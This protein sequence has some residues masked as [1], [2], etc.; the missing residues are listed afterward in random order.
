MLNL[1]GR[2]AVRCKLNLLLKMHFNRII[3]KADS[4]RP[5]P[6]LQAS[7]ERQFSRENDFIIGFKVHILWEANIILKNLLLL[8][9]YHLLSNFKT[10]WEIFVVISEYLNYMYLYLY[11]KILYSPIL[12]PFLSGK[13]LLA[14]NGAFRFFPCVW[15]KPQRM[16]NGSNLSIPPVQFGKGPGKVR[17][18]HN[19]N[20][21]P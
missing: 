14:A 21:W 13:F 15:Q 19:H 11:K 10:K 9:W 7:Q 1:F 3:I 16:R 18:V 6:L 2:Q 20:I 8:F 4:N 5:G 17:H 12:C